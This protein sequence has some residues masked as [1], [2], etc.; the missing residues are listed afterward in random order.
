MLIST[1][2]SKTQRIEILEFLKSIS[3]AIYSTIFVTLPHPITGLTLK[4]NMK[5]KQY[6]SKLFYLQNQ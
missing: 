3:D 4:F 1:L 6:G 5:A 2:N